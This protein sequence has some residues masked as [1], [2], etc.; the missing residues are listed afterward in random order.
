MDLDYR[1]LLKENKEQRK[2]MEIW[3]CFRLNISPSIVTNDFM[4]Y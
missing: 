4:Q 2:A 3:N 1:T